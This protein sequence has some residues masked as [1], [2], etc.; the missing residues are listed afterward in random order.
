MHL[1]NKH[2][3]NILHTRILNYNFVIKTKY[4]PLIKCAS[5]MLRVYGCGPKEHMKSWHLVSPWFGESKKIIP[6]TVTFV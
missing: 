5:S 2:I 1:S 4:G 3:L 6:Q